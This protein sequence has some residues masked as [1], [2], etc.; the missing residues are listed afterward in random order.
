MTRLFLLLLVTLAPPVQGQTTLTQLRDDLSSNG[1]SALLSRQSLAQLPDT[2][3]EQWGDSQPLAGFAV[4]GYNRD[5]NRFAARLR[6]QFA[7]G[8]LNYLRVEG[9]H[10][11]PYTITD[12]YD[13]ATGIRLSELANLVPWLKTDKGN[14]FLRTLQKQPDNAELARQVSNRPAAAAL[15]LMQCTGQPCETLARRHQQSKGPALWAV[16]QALAAE[17]QQTYPQRRKEL[18]SALGDDSHFLYWEGQQVLIHRACAWAGEQ[19][20]ENWRRHTGNK[21][22]ADVALLCALRS[23]EAD[24]LIAKLNAL[25]Q[26][27]PS[28]PLAQALDNYYPA[29]TMPSALRSWLSQSGRP[30]GEE[31]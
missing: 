15:W 22:L 12:W 18:V 27:L 8:G 11:T 20:W 9:R 1:I 28:L 5:D 26:A 17:N 24:D 3:R 30:A 16:Q 31:E 2:L 10:G 29:D 19:T 6:L 13:Y 25:N 14:A 23:H 7:A 21:Q 4:T